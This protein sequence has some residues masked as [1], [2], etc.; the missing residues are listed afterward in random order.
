[1]RTA[2]VAAAACLLAGCCCPPVD[3]MPAPP[4]PGADAPPAPRVLRP[5]SPTNEPK[6]PELVELETRQVLAGKRVKG[7]SWEEVNLDQAVAYLR[8][9]TGLNFYVTPKVREELLEDVVI[10]LQLDDVSI[11]QVLDLITE[12]YGM[13]WEVREGVVWILSQRNLAGPLR[14]RYYDVKDLVGPQPPSKPYR[15][16]HVL[17]DEVKLEVHPRYW[18]SEKVALEGRNRILIVRASRPVLDEVDRYLSAERA[19]VL[20][21]GL[22]AAMKTRF[23]KT[24]INLSV[25][26]QPLGDVLKTLMIQSGFNLVLDPRVESDVR[27]N[28]VTAMELRDSS[29]LV[30]LTMLTAAAGDDFVWIGQ[31]NVATLTRKEFV[32]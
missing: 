24:K 1:M 19:R 4:E 12:P 7:L 23:E 6:P 10:T 21:P 8:T 13:R 32:R 28:P 29:L 14:L 11:A 2:L 5:T 9:I 16:I 27:D 3:V 18:E 22:P 15:T 30:A 20:R 31:G 26:D 17:V 25:K